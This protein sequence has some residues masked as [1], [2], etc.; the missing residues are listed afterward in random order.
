MVQGGVCVCVCGGGG[1]GEKNLKK[2]K[3]TAR[4]SCDTTTGIGWSV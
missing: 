4:N 1:M 3:N 2:I